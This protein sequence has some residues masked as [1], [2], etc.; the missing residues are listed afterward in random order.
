[1]LGE[2]KV[3]VKGI[4]GGIGFILSC[5]IGLISGGSVLIVLVRAFIF[6]VFFFV[7]I[8]ISQRLIG[9]FLP[10]LL[11]PDADASSVTSNAPGSRVDISVEDETD[12]DKERID[13]FETSGALLEQI[14]S[15]KDSFTDDEESLDQEHK[16][17][18]TQQKG[19]AVDPAGFVP[20]APWSKDLAQGMD[21][22]VGTNPLFS[23]DE[24]IPGNI[25]GV[26]SG[27]AQNASGLQSRGEHLDP[28]KMAS[29]IQT[30]LKQE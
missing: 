24:A 6:G 8:E 20:S 5:I 12:T 3:R 15:K 29:A 23:T 14:A 17:E 11:N 4:A 21:G 22:V 18:Y 27:R 9:A 1:V 2:K 25:P 28:K 13:L 16:K 30:I 19:V 26:A 7:F 10:E